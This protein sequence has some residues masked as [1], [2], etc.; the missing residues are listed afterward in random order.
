MSSCAKRAAGSYLLCPESLNGR[1]ASRIR[2]VPGTLGLVEDYVRAKQVALK[3]PET[4][5]P[6]LTS[7]NG[8]GEPRRSWPCPFSIVSPGTVMRCYA[9]I[10]W[11]RA[12]DAEILVLRHQLAVLRRQVARPRFT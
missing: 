1:S 5:C 2:Q 9:S 3:G 4:P 7:H 11:M 12:K 8:L 10:G 6:G